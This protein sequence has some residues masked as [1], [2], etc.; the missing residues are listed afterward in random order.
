[1]NSGQQSRLEGCFAKLREQGR[2]GL[3]TFL[4]AGDPDI[5]TSSL[6]LD[7]LVEGGADVI[8]LGIPF[9]DPMA[10]G[11]AIQ[12][13]SLRALQ[14][15][16]SLEKTL[17]LAR[18]F[19]ARHE[20][21]PLVLMGYYN[22]IH[23]YGGER[24]AEAAEQAGVDGLIIVDLPPEEEDE[25]R[26]HTES[27]GID[28]IRLITPTSAGER[29]ATLLQNARGFLYYV[30][31][32]GIT[33]TQRAESADLRARIEELRAHQK[34][35]VPIAVGFGL[36]TQADVVPLR[37]VADAVVIGSVLVECVA[38]G[39]QNGKHGAALGY[40]VA[41]CVRGFHQVLD[42]ALDGA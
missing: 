28:W 35:A 42:G 33:G 14:A 37:G 26:A 25:L 41:E 3:I 8:E 30:A 11:K 31:V 12:E 22:P 9:S 5:E 39:V 10:D 2:T 6:L 36:R 21:V 13:A 7:S 4:T 27:R 20:Q 40:E 16:A 32:K 19:R 29:L 1:M 34:Q 15:G 38:A 17:D 23:H 18:G 24:F